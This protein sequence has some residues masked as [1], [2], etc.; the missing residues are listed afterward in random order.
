MNMKRTLS[1]VA[2]TGALV[3]TATACGDY[4]DRDRC[5]T[6]TVLIYSTTDHRYHYGST[7]GKL[8]PATKVPNSA[9]KVPGYKPWTPPKAQHTNP[10]VPGYKAP[11]PKAKV[12]AYKAPAPARRR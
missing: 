3:V 4:N 7:T 10:K 2:L 1:A 11:A 12:P 9:R 6:S 8:V 5:G